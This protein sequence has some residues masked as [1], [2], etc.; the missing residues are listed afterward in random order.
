MGT[1]FVKTESF[2]APWFSD[3]GH[4]FV[5][6][7]TASEALEIV[8]A[9]YTHPCGL[10][11][12]AAWPSSDAMHKGEAPSATW[13][14]NHEIE[15]RRLTENL[16]SYSYLGRAPGDFEIDHVRHLIE[17]PKQGRVFEK[18]TH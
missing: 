13:M 18:D 6:A 9:L 2:A 3:T 15:R 11:A 17:N 1:W 14:C 5:A 12:A 8:A 10:Y 4:E 7:E 16:S